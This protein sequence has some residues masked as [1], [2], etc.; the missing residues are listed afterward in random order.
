[1]S[2]IFNP[3]FSRELNPVYRQTGKCAGSVQWNANPASVSLF[4]YFS[5]ETLWWVVLRQRI[6]SPSQCYLWSPTHEL[7]FGFVIASSTEKEFVIR[8]GYPV[9]TNY[10]P[11]SLQFKTKATESNRIKLQLL[12]QT[13]FQRPLHEDANFVLYLLFLSLQQEGH[14]LTR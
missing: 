3:C 11:V 12:H 14:L 2:P 7:Q 10:L 8:H 6:Y 4:P 13:T 9:E 5:K 1:M